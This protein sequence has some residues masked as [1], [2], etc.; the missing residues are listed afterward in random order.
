VFS[1]S[2]AGRLTSVSL[3][4]RAIRRDGH[5]ALRSLARPCSATK[6]MI[7]TAT[8]PE[9]SQARLRARRGGAK[10]GGPPEESLVSGKRS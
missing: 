1:P 9:A 10:G 2:N 7:G 5:L 6:P 4:F 8:T 3:G